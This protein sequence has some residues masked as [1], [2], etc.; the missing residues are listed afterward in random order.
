MKVTNYQSATIDPFGK[1]LGMV[2]GTGIQLSDA[3]RLD[4]NLLDEDVSLPAAVL[5]ADRIEHNLKWMQ[6][7]VAEYGVKLAPHGKTTMAPQLFR[8]QLEAGAWGIT[9]A[10]AHQV[11]A[12]YRGGVHRVLLANQLVGKRNMG[13]IAELLTDPEFRVLLS[14]RFS[15]R[16][17]SAG[18]VFQRREEKAERADRARRA[19]R[20]NR[21]ARRR[22][23]RSRAGGH[24]AL[25]GHH[26]SRGHRIVRR[27][28][29]G[30]VE[31]ARIPAKRGGDHAL[32]RRR[33]EDHAQA[34]D[35]VGRGFGVVRRR[36]RR[37]REGE[38]RRDRSRAAAGL[39][40]DA[41]R[42]HLQEGAERDF[43]AQSDREEDGRR[44]QAGAATV[45]VRAVDSGAGSRDHRARQARFRLRCRDARA[46]APLSAG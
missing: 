38:Q 5:Y 17:R 29:A 36:R 31:S 40:S 7:F 19:G 12:A 3:A 6:A 27:R 8:R 46:G 18:H 9:L 16:R 24:R 44:A 35:S 28:A 30:R 32:A 15:G 2:P 10:T 11:R 41:R 45:G 22:A 14:G 33:R 20:P 1:G 37:I 23:A 43:R 4:W 39:L 42:R 26:S 13:M 34:G 21:R 25:A